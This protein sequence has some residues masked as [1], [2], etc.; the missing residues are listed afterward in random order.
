M[1]QSIFSKYGLACVLALAAA[2]YAGAQTTLG[3]IDRG[4]LAETRARIA[5][6]P[7][8]SG[9]EAE[10]CVFTRYESAEAL[11]ALESAG[12]RVLHSEKTVAL[13]AMP[14]DRVEELLG[15]KGV[16]SASLPR[17]ARKLNDKAR[18]ASNVDA[19]HA[20]E[21]LDRSYKG[22]GVIV[23]IFDMGFDPNHINFND[24]EG[25]SRVKHM[26]TYL[27]RYEGVPPTVSRNETPT[28]IARFS[29]D[30]SDDTH[31][32]HVIG[33]AAG[34]FSEGPAADYAGVAPEAEIF[35]CGG[36]GSSAEMVIAFADMTEYAASVGKPLVINLSLGDNEGSHDGT[37]EFAMMLD[38][39]AERTGAHF[40]LA[41]GNEG[42]YGIG[43]YKEFAGDDTT[44][45]TCLAPDDS[46]SYYYAPPM[47]GNIEVWSE[48]DTP[49]TLYIDLVDKT[50]PDAPV[51]S[52]EIPRDGGMY[53]VN[54]TTPTG[55]GAGMINRDDS[56]F[57][58][59]YSQSYI[60][61]ETA[62]SPQNG[63]FYS[64]VSFDLTA[65]SASVARNY[66]MALRI[67]G[68]AGQKVY[69]Y[70][71]TSYDSYYGAYF[72]ASFE[73]FNLPGYTAS[74]GNGSISGMACG[75][76][77][78]AVGAYTTRN[79]ASDAFY[80]RNQ[81]IG[82]PVYFSSWGNIPGGRM[83][84]DISAPGFLIVSS[85]SGPYVTANNRDL[86]SLGTLKYYQ[87]TDPATSKTHYWTYMAGT[88]MATPF[89]TG[90]AAL[91][92]EA[93]PSLSTEDIRHIAQA[94]A[95]MPASENPQWGG[96]GKVDALAGLKMAIGYSDVADVAADGGKETILFT[97]KGGALYEV[98]AP[99]DEEVSASVYSLSGALLHSVSGRGAV[100][101]DLSAVPSGVYLLKASTRRSAR[102]LKIA[103]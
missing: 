14:A 3:I 35:M 21:G 78:I 37:D 86:S 98:F 5:Q 20:G 56:Q 73:S 60:G 13:V 65:K 6:N 88:S 9:E 61:A 52:I 77:T 10:V 16:V 80:E 30:S 44:L 76:N 95:M 55:V 11:A 85:M 51:T 72:P 69:A 38:E 64:V 58:A 92:L 25:N 47:A 90:V 19:V 91:W 62:L 70:V 50:A 1:N 17:R 87:Y 12:A 99:G 84:P 41:A 18:E 57:N 34:S 74:D 2:G 29:T 59:V 24:S 23:G 67:E 8:R 26:N 97:P 48:D 94:T 15:T 54:G 49:F 42:T 33:T 53:L 96:S 102:S 101:V 75:H 7:S 45:R 68:T 31:A 71:N 4:R 40:F 82:E 43:L 100:D 83:K 46:Y 63:R 81:P 27:Q 32:T 36:Y 79:I 39:I 103:L 89:M 28:A 93:N 22:N 66:N